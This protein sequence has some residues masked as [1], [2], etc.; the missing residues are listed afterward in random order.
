MVLTAAEKKKCLIFF[1]LNYLGINENTIC[2]EKINPILISFF[3]WMIKITIDKMLT[4]LIA[5]I[6]CN[7]RNRAKTDELGTL[8]RKILITI[9]GPKRNLQG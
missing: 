8:E 7:V 6:T 1:N 5:S 9:F 4:W 3:S 2:H